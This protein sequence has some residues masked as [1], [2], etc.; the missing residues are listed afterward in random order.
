MQSDYLRAVLES[1]YKQYEQQICV[2][3]NKADPGAD[4][5]ELEI[6]QNAIMH[7]SV[8]LDKII[9]TEAE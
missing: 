7:F 6:P 8:K 4:A 2:R 9:D 5:I 3:G 1:E